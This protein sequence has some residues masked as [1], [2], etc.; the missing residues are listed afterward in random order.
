MRGC[1]SLADL[2]VSFNHMPSLRGLLD[3]LPNRKLQALSFNDN[4][5]SAISN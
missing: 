4:L 1:P 5:F 2:D 3:V